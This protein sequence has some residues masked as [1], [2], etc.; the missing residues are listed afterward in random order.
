MIT[1]DYSKTLTAFLNQVSPT[2]EGYILAKN[3]VEKKYITYNAVVG[4]DGEEFIQ[5]LSIYAK[6]TSY[7]KV[8]EIAD[9]LENIITSKGI[10]IDSSWGVM[11]IYKGSPYYQNKAD[12]DD[13]IRAGYINLRIKLWQK[14]Y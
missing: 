3:V 11:T 7:A 12:E 6:Y 8:K 13:N 14:K 9:A 4:D 1:R 5:P 2:Y 10:K